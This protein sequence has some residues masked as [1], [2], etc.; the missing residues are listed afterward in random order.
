MQA[1]ELAAGIPAVSEVNGARLARSPKYGGTASEAVPKPDWR[2]WLDAVDEVALVPAGVTDLRLAERLLVDQ[3]IARPRQLTGRAEA[4]TRY[5][6]ALAYSVIDFMPVFVRDAMDA[7]EFD[8]A[9]EALT[10]AVEAMALAQDSAHGQGAAGLAELSR[11]LV[12]DG[13]A[14]LAA[15]VYAV[16]AKPAI[17]GW[18][19][20]PHSERVR[21]E[22]AVAVMHAV[23]RAM[24]A[25]RPQSRRIRGLRR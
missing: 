20:S 13:D 24:N 10:A 14:E 1:I 8:E 4:R 9:M 11:K 16:D 21:I 22:A 15:Q 5:H 19:L 25:P 17:K 3:G 12:H 23:H 6:A 7:C 18:S 2:E